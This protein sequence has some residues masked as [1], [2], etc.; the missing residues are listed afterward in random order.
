MFQ[1][2]VIHALQALESGP[3]TAL[4]VGVT[5]LGYG[6]TFFVVGVALVFGVDFRKGFVLVQVLVWNAI[7]LYFLKNHVALPRPSAVDRTVR[8]LAEGVPNPAPFE[9]GG[10]PGFWDALPADVVAHHRAQPDPSHGFPSGH[11]STTVACWGAVW[12]LFR[13]RWLAALLAVLVVLM[14]VSRLYLGQHFLADVLGGLALGAA[15]LGAAY[16]VVLR[17]DRLTC[18]LAAGRPALRGPGVAAAV[19]LIAAPLVVLPLVPYV[20]VE[21]AAQLL[22]LNVGF[23]LVARRGIPVWTDGAA[24]RAGRVVVAL[25]LYAVVRYVLQ[26]AGDVLFGRE[27]AAWAYVVEAASIALMLWGTVALAG[28]GAAEKSR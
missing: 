11:V 24:R 19:Y 14:P 7:V 4:M 3:L 16:V 13:R 10:A 6:T 20:P 21:H 17:R 1:T 23:A 27:A 12:L 15:V 28:R 5:Y 9:R 26:Q 2:E 25:A 8:L 22:G 18:Y